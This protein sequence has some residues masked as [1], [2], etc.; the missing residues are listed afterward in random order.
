MFISTQ[1]VSS[2]GNTAWLTPL[3]TVI[4]NSSSLL[5]AAFVVCDHQTPFTST[6][7]HCPLLGH[8]LSH[9]ENQRSIPS[10]DRCMLQAAFTLT[11]SG[12]LRIGEFTTPSSKRFDARY[13]STINSIEWN[14]P[15][16]KSDSFNLV[17]MVFIP[18]SN[19]LFCPN[20]AM[21]RHR[22]CRQSNYPQ[23]LF[24]FTEGKPLSGHSC[25][26]TFASLLGNRPQ[27]S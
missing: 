16:T 26:N 14:L 23:P 19:N 25:L 4:I 27:S 10:Q 15:H 17:R 12:F 24:S 1:W 22:K 7:N 9:L 2:T 21:L 6:T 13:N 11:F 5:S 3:T 18:N 8:L 20:T